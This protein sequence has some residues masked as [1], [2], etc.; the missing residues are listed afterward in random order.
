MLVENPSVEIS[1][2]L[3]S[4]LVSDSSSIVGL[5]RKAEVMIDLEECAYKSFFQLLRSKD[6]FLTMYQV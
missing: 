5:E 1:S 4:E 2:V 6:I 3:E